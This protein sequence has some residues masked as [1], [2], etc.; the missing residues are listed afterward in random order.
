MDSNNPLCILAKRID[1][2]RIEE[3]LSKYYSKRGRPAKPIRLM[4]GLLILKHIR[5]LSDES[6]VREWTENLYFQFFCGGKVF[7]KDAPCHSTDLVH[8]RKRIGKAGIEMILEESI[9]VNGE[10]AKEE[11]VSTDTTVQEKNI[12]FPT[13]DKLY[14]KVIKQC[15]KISEEAKVNIRQ[16]YRRTI[17]KLSLWQRF[18]RSKKYKGLAHKADKKIKRIAGRLVRELERKLPENSLYR[19]KIALFKR[20]LSQKRED[21]E[22]IYSLHEPE[23]RCISKGKE[24]KPYEFGNKVSIT[25]TQNSGVIVGAMSFRSEY[26]GHILEPVMEQVE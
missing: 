11:H 7:V 13:D 6:V 14:K 8:F 26:D 9:R 12:T 3:N 18:R 25:I 16:S 24:H 23:V 15:L 19:E 20:V 5:N 10:D 2:K 21:R 17:K 1:W 22:K 4:A